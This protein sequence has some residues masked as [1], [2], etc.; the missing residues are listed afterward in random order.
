MNINSFDDLNL[1]DYHHLKKTF[2]I[3][4]KEPE[5]DYNLT[6][7][8]HQLNNKPAKAGNAPPGTLAQAQSKKPDSK[9]TTHPLTRGE[10]FFFS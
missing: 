3:P 1:T 4:T 5:K 10:N 7:S 8:Q 6:Q 2:S 9:A